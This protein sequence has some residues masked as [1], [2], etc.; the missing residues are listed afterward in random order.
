MADDVFLAI[1]LGASSGR[2]IAAEI[3]ESTI[4]LNEVYRFDNNPV[5]VGK[6][7]L[8]DVLRLWSEVERG[9][10]LSAQKF[11]SRIRSVG[12]DTWGVDYVLLDKNDDLVG[13]PFCYRDARTTG[14]MD[15]AFGKISK[16]EIFQN[17]GVQFMEINTL[18]QLLSMRAESSP[19]LDVADRFLMMPDFFHWQL[20]G[21]K[22]NEYTNASTTQFLDPTTR[23]WSTK[24]L[25]ALDIPSRLF[26]EPIQPA[27]KLGPLRERLI[28]RTGLPNDC[29]VTAPATHDTGSA[30]IAVPAKDFA[31]AKPDWCYISCGTWSLMGIEVAEPI[32]NERCLQLNF[33]NEGGA[34]GSVRLLKNIAGLWPFQQLRASWQRRGK[35]LA[36]DVMAKMAEAAPAHQAHIDL[37][38]RRFVAPDDMLEEMENY[39]KATGQSVSDDATMARVALESLALKYRTCLSSLEMLA[40]TRIEVIHMVGGGIQNRLL[41]QM[42]ADACDRTVVA[43]PVEATAL[44][45]VIA[46]CVASGRFQSILEARQWMRNMPDICTYEPKNAKSWN[47]AV[48][49]FHL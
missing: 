36:W 30:V 18:Y 10:E 13:P 32:L 1:D 5:Y 48:A 12:A 44:G 8:W 41:C 17:S 26:A 37:D 35:S 2:V 33:T 20:S 24:I 45:N 3:H 39:L 11:G 46:Q 47:D 43:G 42:T 21:I 27:T 28:K 23:H 40:G 49:R 15:H 34:E 6:R 9:L 29:V 19:L 31:P 14:M 4:S 7:L 38:D 16:K 22:T 25:D